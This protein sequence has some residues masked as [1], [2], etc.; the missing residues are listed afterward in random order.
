MSKKS[1]K[2]P[3]VFAE[4]NFIF[5]CIFNRDVNAQYLLD[6]AT[7]DRIEMCI[8]RFA[9]AESKGQSEVIIQRRIDNLQ[10]AIDNL[11][12]L[13]RS[14]HRVEEMNQLIDNLQGVINQLRQEIGIA[15]TSI[16]L[17]ESTCE[18]IPYNMEIQARAR[19]RVIGRQP[20]FA[21]NDCVIYESIL[22]FAEQNQALDLPMLFLTRNR[23][24]FDYP[25]IHQEL[26]ELG[27][28]LF[29]E[30]G[31]CVRRVRQLL[32]LRQET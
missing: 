16:D 29:F 1:Q 21:E 8:P 30:P 22:W 11:R 15:K 20:P 31:E 17:I 4:T 3:T 9:L 32:E 12:E 18:I 7:Q 23:R 13:R 19:L 25:S 14:R 28:E 2:S 5:D 10:I 24:D 6:L 27:I 26:S